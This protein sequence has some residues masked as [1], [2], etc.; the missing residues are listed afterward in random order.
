MTKVY[1]DK[2]CGTLVYMNY[3][4]PPVSIK[5]HPALL[6][7]IAPIEQCGRHVGSTGTCW[8][9]DATLAIVKGWCEMS[10]KILLFD[11]DPQFLVHGSMPVPGVKRLKVEYLLSG[12]VADQNS[13]G[14]LPR[15]LLTKGDC[16]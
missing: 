11:Y 10:D 1:P 15:D 8:E 16:R 13:G 3:L 14:D 4:L 9:R 2:E 6:N 5:P 12:C 7:V